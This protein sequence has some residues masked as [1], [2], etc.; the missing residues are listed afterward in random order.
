MSTSASPVARPIYGPAPH[1]ISPATHTYADTSVSAAKAALASRVAFSSPFSSDH[2]S[3]SA[4]SAATATAAAAAAGTPHAGAHGHYAPGYTNSSSSNSSG[5]P[6]SASDVEYYFTDCFCAGIYSQSYFA[7]QQQSSFSSAGAGAAATPSGAAAGAGDPLVSAAAA[8]VPPE[9]RETIFA[10]ALRVLADVLATDVDPFVPV[11]PA[12][13]TALALPATTPATVTAIANNSSSNG[14]AGANANSASAGAGADVTATL[15]QGRIPLLSP[16]LSALDTAAAAIAPPRSVALYKV[17]PESLLGAPFDCA[18]SLGSPQ[19]PAQSQCGDNACPAHG[20]LHGGVAAHGHDC[21]L[22]GHSSARH[23]RDR[24]HAATVSA[25]NTGS[26]V[27]AGEWQQGGCGG[28]VDGLG[29]TPQGTWP[30]PATISVGSSSTHTSHYNSNVSGLTIT[31]PAHG[32]GPQALHTPHNPSSRSQSLALPSLPDPHCAQSPSQSPQSAQSQSCS[33]SYSPCCS[34]AIPICSQQQNRPCS[35]VCSQSSPAVVIAGAKGSLPPRRILSQA[36][37]ERVVEAIEVLCDRL[38]ERRATLL[39]TEVAL[40]NAGVSETTA[41]VRA[42][43]G[44]RNRLITA[45]RATREAV[46]H[47]KTR[48]AAAADAVTLAKQ[49]VASAEEIGMPPAKAAKL[50]KSL[51]EARQRRDVVARELDR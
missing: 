11:P 9:Y 36:E 39:S 7:A 43:D 38:L 48:L 4:A 50:V 13:L 41:W 10:L 25:V 31:P 22:H 16:W 45:V 17:P 18:Q 47:A 33:Q 15:F 29:L 35:A 1:P 42:C 40:H 21:H 6:A 27:T 12:T 3:S 28:G 49:A 19:S 37:V 46:D 44:Q 51:A 5:G 34:Q 20:H 26:A 32:H 24:E 14:D 23:S 2:G 8:T 30:E